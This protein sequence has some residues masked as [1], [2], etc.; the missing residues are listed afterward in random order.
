V[1]RLFLDCLFGDHPELGTELKQVR[2]LQCQATARGDPADLLI[3]EG[4]M[5]LDEG[6]VRE[7]IRQGILGRTLQMA[8]EPPQCQIAMAVN[9]P[10]SGTA[11]LLANLVVRAFEPIVRKR[12]RDML[13]V[14]RPCS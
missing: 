5:A 13:H 7:R 10:S 12:G 14:A 3:K 1:T 9:Q 2:L 11:K 6:T 4:R 8:L